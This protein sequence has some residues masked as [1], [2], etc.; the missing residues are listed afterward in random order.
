L[1]GFANTFFEASGDRLTP[2]GVD[3]RGPHSAVGKD[4]TC[5]SSNRTSMPRPS[6]RP[7][8]GDARGEVWCRRPAGSQAGLPDRQRS[9]DTPGR[10][11]RCCSDSR[12]R[13]FA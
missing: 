2:V 6:T 8:A 13:R 1:V 7:G 4:G 12:E 11:P 9:C 3:G 5:G 10:N